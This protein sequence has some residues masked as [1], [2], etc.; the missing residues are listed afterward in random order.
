MLPYDRRYDLRPLAAG[1]QQ[2]RA[3]F[4]LMREGGTVGCRYFQRPVAMGVLSRRRC[5]VIAMV[6]VPTVVMR[7]PG[8]VV[9]AVGD[10]R[11]VVVVMVVIL[12]RQPVQSVPQQRDDAVQRQQG[13]AHQ[14][15][16]DRSH[17]RNASEIRN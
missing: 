6:V 5:M 1:L 8:M 9:L 17:A 15:S 4:A 2:K 11:A 12:Q 14:L 16:I 3:D 10:L 13:A 7:M